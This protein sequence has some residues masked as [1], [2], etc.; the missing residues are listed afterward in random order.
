MILNCV[1]VAQRARRKDN[2]VN[3]RLWVFL[4]FVMTTLGVIG[5]ILPGM[6]TTIFILIAVWAFSKG[7]P[8]FA[9]YL[10]SHRFFGPPIEE[11]KRNRAIPLKAKIS[12]VCMMGLSLT[13]LLIWSEL[14][15]YT[16]VFIGGVMGAA[17]TWIMSRPTSRTPKKIQD[18][19]TSPS[20][21]YAD[22]NQADRS[23]A[24]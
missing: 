12:A 6:P 9:A 2:A 21:N 10:E 5:A 11:W 17:A 3:R 18:F 19:D 24:P 7:N 4:G 13:A 8:A 16:L 14:S 23:P 20:A 22:K 1:K 15:V